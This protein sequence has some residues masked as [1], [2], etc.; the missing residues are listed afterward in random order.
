MKFLLTAF[1][2]MSLIIVSSIGVLGAI[3]NN[4]SD[5]I[6]W[7]YSTEG[8]TI[9][10]YIVSPSDNWFNIRPDQKN[11]TFNFYPGVS[12]NLY[13]LSY[14]ENDFTYGELLYFKNDGYGR[15]RS[16][17]G[18][19]LFDFGLILGVEYF[20]EDAGVYVLSPGYALKFQDLGYAAFSFDYILTDDFKKLTGYD[21]DLKYTTDSMKL[22]A[23]YYSATDN[24]PSFVGI[25][26]LDNSLDLGIILKA[27]DQLTLGIR[28]INSVIE[29]IDYSLYYAGFTWDSDKAIVDVR[30]GNDDYLYLDQNFYDV[31]GIVK[32]AGKYGLGFGYTKYEG[33]PD[34]EIKLKFKYFV[35]NST[36]NFAYTIDNNTYDDYWT[37]SY[38]MDL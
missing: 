25:G 16:L 3:H 10:H 7:G 6:S 19:T 9:S 34:A 4:H 15:A 30:F 23:Q 20:G 31:S 35:D 37:L 2:V 5:L 33:A 1:L 29:S 26:A 17:R 24:Y 21:F 13:S 32:I 27:S 38:K 18:S 11:V 14:Y 28:Y 12:T 22:F 8:L 36:F